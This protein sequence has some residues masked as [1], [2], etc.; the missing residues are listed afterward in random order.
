MALK[1]GSQPFE[2]C[3]ICSSSVYVNSVRG[4]RKYSTDFAYLAKNRLTT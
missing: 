3:A 2:E 4:Y 1:I